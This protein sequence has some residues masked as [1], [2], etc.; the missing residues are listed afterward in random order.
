MKY[1]S[2]VKRKHVIPMQAGWNIDL[3]SRKRVVAVI[4]FD[5]SREKISYTKPSYQRYLRVRRRHKISSLRMPVERKLASKKISDLVGGFKHFL[6]SPLFG[7][8]IQFD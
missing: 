8:M 1:H 6:F 3:V 5:H 7:E 4:E 2:P